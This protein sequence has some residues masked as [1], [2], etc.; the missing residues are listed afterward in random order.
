MSKDVACAT[1]VHR[2]NFLASVG[3]L[4]GQLIC[5]VSFAKSPRPRQRVIIDN[6]FSGDPDGLFQ[7]AHHLLSPSIAI[8][9]VIGSHIHRD[10][11]LDHSELQADNAAA[12]AHAL[13]AAMKLARAPEI[14]AGRNASPVPS[15]RPQRTVVTDRIIAEA[16]RS[17]TSV[18][19]VYAAGAGLT[20]LAEA[21]RIAPSI[22]RRIRL[23]WIGGMEWPQLT[24]PALLKTAPEYNMT[25]DLAAVRTIFNASDIEIWQVPRNVYRLAVVSM[26]ELRARLAEAGSLG[27]FLVTSLDSVRSRWDDQMGETYIL[28][29]SPLV[30]LTALLSAFEPDTSSSSYVVRSTP[31][32]AANGSYILQAS[33]RPMRVYRS[34]DT[35]LTFADMFAKFAA[36][37]Q[38][39]GTSQADG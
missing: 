28:G 23:V 9:F 20:E 29:D 11:F 37:G 8:P 24:A 32:I 34:I 7:L 12:R 21:V 4:A 30:T 27:S 14:L 5:P 17:D 25:I 15:A 1:A 39:K 22:G 2:R 3:F 36:L 13:V 26:A 33:G 19:L 16:N 18:P 31:L 38:G 35:R 6:D 10:D